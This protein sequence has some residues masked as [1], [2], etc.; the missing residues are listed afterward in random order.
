MGID[1]ASVGRKV[2]E[3]CAEQ[4]MVEE[5]RKRLGE[6]LK[7]KTGNCEEIRLTYFPARG[8]AEISRLILKHAGV[9][10]DD[11]R[12]TGE[13]FAKVKPIL[14]YKGEV[15][16]ESMAIAAFLAD[17]CNL[18]GTNAVEKAKANEI[19]LAMNGL[20]ETIAK[21]LFSPEGE[22]AGMRRSCLRRLC[23]RSSVSWRA[24]CASMGASSSLATRSLTPISCSLSFK[25]TSGLPSS[26]VGTSLRS[27]QRCAISSRGCPVFQTSRHG[28]AQ[29]RLTQCSTTETTP[30]LILTL[31]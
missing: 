11:I 29:D 31:Y 10:F 4:K 5:L 14:E 1:S 8:R 26:A 13:D 20:F 30:R 23:P 16:C 6:S 25:I 18:A 28:E 7:V 12:L 17:I 2:R 15:L 27:S 21:I 3:T 19:V 22:K 9:K 24:G